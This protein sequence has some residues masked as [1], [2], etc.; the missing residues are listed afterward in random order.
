MFQTMP[1]MSTTASPHAA[2]TQHACVAP[3]TILKLSPSH[4]SLLSNLTKDLSCLP[5]CA[6][7]FST[8]QY[9]FPCISSTLPFSPHEPPM[10]APESP[11]EPDSVGSPSRITPSRVEA[12]LRDADLLD[13]C[14]DRERCLDRDQC[15]N[16][17][18]YLDF[19][20]Y[21]DR[22]RHLDQQWW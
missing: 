17:D 10:A 14:L 16:R 15:L 18:R 4:P 7:P 1:S 21:L 9:I 3:T 19:D 2:L 8:P 11:D 5:S 20:W 12:R 6:P 22:D 13:R